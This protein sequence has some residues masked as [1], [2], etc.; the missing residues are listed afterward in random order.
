MQHLVVTYLSV[1][2]DIVELE[3]PVELV[4]HLASASNAEG[5]DEFFKVDAPRLVR[6][7]NVEYIVGKRARIAKRKELSVDFL[8]LFFTQHAR[9]TI[10]E[11]A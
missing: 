3:R 9:G 10:L 11:K 4:L 1:S 8:K 6:V 7:E 5:A 2:I